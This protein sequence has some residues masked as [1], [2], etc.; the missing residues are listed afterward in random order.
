MVGRRVSLL[1]A[2]GFCATMVAGCGSSNTSSG[3]MHADSAPAANGS[4]GGAAAPAQAPAEKNDQQ[5]AQP[6]LDRKL[7]RTANLELAA[8]DVVDITNKARDIAVAL[9]GFAGQEQV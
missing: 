2:A 3:V 9:G 5:V 1:V 7:I 6:G 4:G 8:P